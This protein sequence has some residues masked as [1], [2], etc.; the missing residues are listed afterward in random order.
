MDVVYIV[1]PGGGNPELLLS[2]RSLV[3]LPH[4]RVWIIGT[5]PTQVT[6]VEYVRANGHRTKALNVF[7]NVLTACETEGVSD[8]FVMMNDDF[9]ILERP[10]LAPL[11]RCPLEEHVEKVAHRNDSWAKSIRATQ[12]WLTDQV[13]DLRSFELHMPIVIDKAKMADTLRSVGDFGSPHLPQWRTVYGNLH[14]SHA[15]QVPDCKL[16]RTSDLS[17]L[18]S[19]TFASSSDSSFPRIRRKL[20][21]R[22]PEPSPY[23]VTP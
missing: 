11:Y 6:N 7:H 3:N 13:S 14:V 9:Y 17:E 1:R 20:L 10:D 21:E 15:E 2:L 12:E 18:L 8:E 23:E 16:R 19:G 5:K 22:F 4:D